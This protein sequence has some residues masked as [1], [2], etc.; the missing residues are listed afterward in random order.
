MI[1]LRNPKR[2]ALNLRSRFYTRF[3][4]LVLLCLHNAP[5]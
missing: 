5:P 3:L 1:S 2:L 4:H